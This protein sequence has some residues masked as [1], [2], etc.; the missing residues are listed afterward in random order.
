MQT[1][2]GRITSDAKINETKDGRKVVNF[3]IAENY[4]YKAKGSEEVKQAANFYHCSYW[5]NTN[6]SQ[7]LRKGTLVETCGRLGINAWKNMEGEAKAS[8][9][10]HVNFIQLHGSKKDSV[11]APN[12]DTTADDLP[13]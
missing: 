13:F 11:V 1:V 7:H 8:L 12:T 9:N 6:I 10:L 2:I 5:L 4:R 3:T